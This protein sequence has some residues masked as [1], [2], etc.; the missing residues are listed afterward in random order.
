MMISSLRQEFC[1]SL[2]L[3][4]TSFITLKSCKLAE[5]NAS[6]ALCVDASVKPLCQT[7]CPSGK[8]IAMRPEA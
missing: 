4:D 2:I 8:H 3:H 5:A 7:G 6:C 1:D